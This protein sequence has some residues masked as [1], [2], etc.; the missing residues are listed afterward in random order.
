MRFRELLCYVYLWCSP[1]LI[2]FSVNKNISIIVLFLLGFFCKTIRRLFVKEL[3][4]VLYMGEYGVS[5]YKPKPDPKGT[6]YLPLV[7]FYKLILSVIFLFTCTPLFKPSIIVNTML[8]LGSIA[9]YMVLHIFLHEILKR[10]FTSSKNIERYLP[11]Y[12]HC[13]QVFGKCSF[14]KKPYIPKAKC[15]WVKIDSRTVPYMYFDAIFWEFIGLAIIFPCIGWFIFH[16]HLKEQ[17]RYR[18]F[19]H[20]INS[21]KEWWDNMYNMIYELHF[22]VDTII[23]FVVIWLYTWYVR[24]ML[25]FIISCT[26][27]SKLAESTDNLDNVP[28]KTRIYIKTTPRTNQQ[29]S[30]SYALKWSVPIIGGLHILHLLIKNTSNDWIFLINVAYVCIFLYAIYIVLQYHVNEYAHV[31]IKVFSYKG[32]RFEFYKLTDNWKW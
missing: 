30:F 12:W 31:Y 9:V 4:K 26:S 25:Q 2:L 13:Q 32:E 24:R 3:F 14:N 1:I 17:G 15:V 16:I 18:L 23:I 19:I 20:A 5:G 8:L 22:I 21:I 10:R 11:L 27:K 28:E 29:M 7:N 6:I